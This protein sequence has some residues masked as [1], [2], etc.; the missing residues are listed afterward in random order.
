MRRAFC[1]R[2][3][4]L[5]ASDRPASPVAMPQALRTLDI[6]ISYSELSTPPPPH[7]TLLDYDAPQVL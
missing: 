4:S 1:L 3:A 7:A 5:Q 2:T 6:D